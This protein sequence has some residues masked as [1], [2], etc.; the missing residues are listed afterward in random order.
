MLRALISRIGR[1][2]KVKMVESSRMLFRRTRAY[3]QIP[4]QILDRRIQSKLGA[5]VIDGRMSMLMVA[6]EGLLEIR[7][8]EKRAT[9]SP[10]SMRLLL[11]TCLQRTT[12]VILDIRMKMLSIQILIKE[13][14]HCSFKAVKAMTK[15]TR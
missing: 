2:M 6:M 13:I 10:N 7:Q 3:S 4:G 14:I 9:N 15:D 5:P 1:S 11:E 12:R 8:M